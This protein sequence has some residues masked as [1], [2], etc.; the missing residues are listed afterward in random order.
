M[1]YSRA[2]ATP[3]PQEGPIA[4][5]S[6]RTYAKVTPGHYRKTAPVWAEPASASGSVRTKEGTTHYKAGDYLA[7]NDPEGKD[8]YAVTS[9]KFLATYEPVN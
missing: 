7:A 6:H 1:R 8:P 4:I 9:E 3:I 2:N 5:R